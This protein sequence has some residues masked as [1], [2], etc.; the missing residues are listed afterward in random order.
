MNDA[1]ASD[2]QLIERCLQRDEAA[3]RL[4]VLRYRALVYSAALRT[5]LDQE[6]AAEVFQ[7]VWT[8][9]YQSMRRIRDP[10]ALPKWLTVTTRRQAL[11]YATR[12]ARPLHELSDDLVDPAALASEELESLQARQHLEE[13]LGRLRTPCGPL[14]RALFLSPTKVSYEEITETLDIPIGSIGPTRSRC[15]RHLRKLLEENA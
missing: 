12:Y 2:G 11:K 4:L 1:S 9:L 15:L 6:G 14:L 5:G 7:T 8:E 3:W 10:Q 13:L